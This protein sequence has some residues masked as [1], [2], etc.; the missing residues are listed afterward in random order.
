MFDRQSDRTSG[1]FRGFCGK[2]FALAVIAGCSAETAPVTL[3]SSEREAIKRNVVSLG[4]RVTSDTEDGLY[5]ALRNTYVNIRDAGGMVEGVYKTRQD[6]DDFAKVNAAIAKVFLE[7]ADN[8]Q[9]AK[10]LRTS[11]SGGSRAPQQA[12]YKRLKI[13][14]SRVPLHLIFSLNRPTT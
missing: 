12:D 8:E 1:A 9:F 7:G 5:L 6:V 3:E 2:L 13:T 10:W 14:L 4:A 11:M